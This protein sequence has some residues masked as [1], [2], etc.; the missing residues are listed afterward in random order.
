MIVSIPLWLRGELFSFRKLSSEQTVGVSLCA[1]YIAGAFQQVL[2]SWGFFYLLWGPLQFLKDLVAL[3]GD[4]L[5][6]T[7]LWYA[8]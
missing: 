2:Q 8:S 4:L 1:L 5:L 7:C 6:T 3:N